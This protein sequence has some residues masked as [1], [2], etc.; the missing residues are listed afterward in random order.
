MKLTGPS[1]VWMAGRVL[2]AVLLVE[3]QLPPMM[4]AVFRED[5]EHYFLRL[6]DLVGEQEK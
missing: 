4:I 1:P 5:L 6:V 2:F 3:H